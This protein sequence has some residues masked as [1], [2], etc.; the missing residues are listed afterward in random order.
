MSEMSVYL[1]LAGESLRDH[2]RAYPSL[3]SGT[4]MS[5][6][7]PASDSLPLPYRAAVD[8]AENQLRRDA[9][10]TTL[11]VALRVSFLSDRREGM[12]DPDLRC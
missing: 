2:P 6:C 1:E 10:V 5:G 8:Q 4:S 9:V 7:T 12:T 3:R 11:D